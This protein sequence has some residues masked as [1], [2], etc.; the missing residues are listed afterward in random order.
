MEIEFQWYHLR[1]VYFFYQQNIYQFSGLLFQQ[2]IGIPMGSNYSP[3]LA[4]LFIL[5]YEA[6][7]LQGFLKNKYIK[8]SPTSSVRYIDDLS[9]NK[10]RN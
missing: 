10:F 7:F 5:A 1:Q 4:D 3:L 8:L 9:V 6:D 2:R